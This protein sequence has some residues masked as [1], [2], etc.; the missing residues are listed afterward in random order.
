[1]MTVDEI[2]KESLWAIR[3][4]GDTDNILVKRITEIMDTQWRWKFLDAHKNELAYYHLSLRQAS[5][6]IYQELM[7]IIKALYNNTF[8]IDQFFHPLNDT[9]VDDDHT[10][11]L[12]NK[13]YLSSAKG[14]GLLRVYALKLEPAYYIVTGCVIKLTKAMQDSEH[15]MTELINLE[16]C[17]NFLINAGV[18]DK[19]GFL[20]SEIKTKK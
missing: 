13:G 10:I 5:S 9:E 17:R 3:Y 2:V 6:I 11:L 15:T 19:E 12:K 4:D 20:G 16:K 7:D 1:M 18:F 14:K 8:E